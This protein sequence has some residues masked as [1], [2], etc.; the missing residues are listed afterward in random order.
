MCLLQ[1]AAEKG[2]TCPEAA[3]TMLNNAIEKNDEEKVKQAEEKVKQA[4]EKVKQAEEKV[5]AAEEKTQKAKPDK[6]IRCTVCSQ[7]FERCK[8]ASK[9]VPCSIDTLQCASN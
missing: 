4:E 8:M 7:L 1:K 2:S 6:A 5:K 3:Q 9:M